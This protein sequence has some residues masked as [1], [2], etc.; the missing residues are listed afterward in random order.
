M[1]H[2]L[3]QDFASGWLFGK[4]LAA[5]NLQPDHDKF[6]NKGKPDAYLANY[7]RLQPVLAKLG[8]QLDPRTAQAL[9][10]REPGLA[11][12][13]LYSIKQALGSMNK[14]MQDDREG[15]ELRVEL[16]L[17]ELGKHRQHQAQ[18]AAAADAAAGIDA[19][20]MTLKRLGGSEGTAEQDR[21][22]AAAGPGESPQAILGRIRAFAPTAAKLAESGGKYL[23]TIKARRQEEVAGRKER[24]ARRRRL[25]VEQQAA[26]ATSESRV[27][28]E[29]LLEVLVRRSGEEQRL[30]QRLWQLRQEKDAMEADRKLREEQYAARRDK[31]WEET[32][33]REA[34]L[35][36]SM[37]AQFESSTQ[38]ELATWHEQQQQR[39]AAKAAA[40][41]KFGEHVAWQVVQL[42]ERV[43]EYRAATA[44]QAVPRRDWRAWVNLFLADDAS[45][46][47]PVVATSPEAAAET[48]SAQ[49]ALNTAELQE[50]LAGQGEWVLPAEAVASSATGATAAVQQHAALGRVVAELAALAQKLEGRQLPLPAAGGSADGVDAVL[51]AADAAAEQWPE[52][53][54]TSTIKAMPLKLAVA[55]EYAPPPPEPPTVEVK[56]TKGGKGAAKPE[57]SA[58][59]G[60][61]STGGA[62]NSAGST[63]GGTPGAARGSC[64]ASSSGG[65]GSAVLPA[66]LAAAAGAQGRGFIIDG[67]PATAEQAVLLEK[68]LTGL[69]LAAEQALVDWASLVA[70]PPLDAL[71]Q[72]QRPLVSGLDAVLVL[73]CKDEALAAKR[74][75]GRRLDPATGRLYH[76]EFDP[77]PANTPGLSERLVMVTG[78]D[79]D[80]AQVPQRLASYA[81]AAGPLSGWLGRFSTLRRPL[82]G[83]AELEEVLAGASDV[84]AG[85]L[86]A[87]KDAQAAKA[88][89]EA[90]HR[91]KESAEKVCRTAATDAAGHAERAKAAAESASA[92]VQRCRLSV[93]DASVSAEAEAIASKAGE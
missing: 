51:T 8:V 39:A 45:L 16:A 91:A 70:P 74:A 84:A 36:R 2:I 3:L 88:A 42:A 57:P 55:R 66:H 60:R 83:G 63:A 49:Q 77:P 29:S 89:A 17:A 20:E 23:A 4:L 1:L 9:I 15:Q 75:L 11:G 65:A 78:S 43:V 58:A 81:A 31:D 34:E 12:K 52:K 10:N 38:Q 21:E 67:F 72:L 19:F 59:G 37:K 71:P 40:H 28:A 86:L 5:F 56:G 93:G 73:S 32:L 6:V 33:R 85:I 7:T 24:E 92:A 76:L 44:G 41:H 87:K 79:N 14:D 13:V 26:R 64:D 27:A 61:R 53:A 22:E 54:E 48:G 50:Y 82:D 35:H 46:G 25:L 80:T 62:A 30:G 47:S 90:A 18:A 68:A 69:D